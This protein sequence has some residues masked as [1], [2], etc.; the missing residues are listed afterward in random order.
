M[1]KKEKN[2]ITCTYEISFRQ[3]IPM[4][5][6]NVDFKQ[7]IRRKIIERLAN[8]L[9]RTKFLNTRNEFSEEENFSQANKKIT[10]Y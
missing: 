1:I 9:C 8:I 3:L 5:Q 7:T 6:Q 10:N 4:N 2:K